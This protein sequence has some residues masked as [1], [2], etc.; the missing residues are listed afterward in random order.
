MTRIF[1]FGAIAIAIFAFGLMLKSI[2]FSDERRPSCA[3][4]DYNCNYEEYLNDISKRPPDF[5]RASMVALTTP[6]SLRRNLDA[7]MSLPDYE[8]SSMLRVLLAYPHGVQR[9]IC[10]SQSVMLRLKSRGQEVRSPHQ[11]QEY[12]R[13]LSELRCHQAAK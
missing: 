5:S 7:V 1:A 4:L 12:E 3:V 6:E 8:S 11:R 13:L 9:K 10:N 2:I